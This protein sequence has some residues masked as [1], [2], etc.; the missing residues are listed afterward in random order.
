MKEKIRDERRNAAIA[1]S[2]DP[3]SRLRKSSGG[4]YKRGD[5]AGTSTS[6]GMSTS[7]TARVSRSGGTALPSIHPYKAAQEMADSEIM[8]DEPI[9]DVQVY[10]PHLYI[11]I[12][13][14]RNRYN[15]I[16]GLMMFSLPLCRCM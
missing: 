6:A 2:Q 1:E 7:T 16:F 12:Y 13:I 9:P 5:N 4:T 15:D 10:T 3:A 14:Y 8:G 11:L